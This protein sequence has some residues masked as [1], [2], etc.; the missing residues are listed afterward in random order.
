MNKLAFLGCA[1]LLCMG[2]L[3]AQEV[4][5]FSFDLG[6]GFTQPVGNTGNYLNDGWNVQGGVGFNFSNY[7]GVMGQLDYNSMGF[8]GATTSALGIPGGGV[9]VFSA[10]LDPIIHLTPRSHFDLYA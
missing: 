9:H 6:G 3:S 1:G 4:S 10:T 8:N 7:I 2:T 5:H